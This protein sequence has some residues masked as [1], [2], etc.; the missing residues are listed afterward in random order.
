MIQQGCTSTR[1]D[2]DFQGILLQTLLP[3][4]KFRIYYLRL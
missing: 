3:A 2:D 1:K 4:A